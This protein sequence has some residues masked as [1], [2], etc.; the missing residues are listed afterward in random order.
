MVLVQNLSW[1]GPGHELRLK[2]SLL[3]AK[4]TPSLCHIDITLYFKLLKLL[5]VTASDLHKLLL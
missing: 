3:L 4:F 1:S 5:N 2:L